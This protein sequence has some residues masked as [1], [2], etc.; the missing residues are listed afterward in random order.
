[1]K[2]CFFCASSQTLSE[3]YYSLATKFA[4]KI[5][6]NNHTLVSGGSNVGL[7]LTLAQSVK[8]INGNSIGIITKEFSERNLTCFD[9]KEIIITADLQERK[10]ILIEI[11]DAFVILPGGF[12]TLDEL[13]EVL[14][15]NHIG[16]IFKP[17]VIFNYNEFYNDL[18][19]MFDKIF[20]NN[21]AQQKNKTSYLVTQNIDETFNYI[22]SNIIQK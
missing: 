12:G 14:T 10:K 22:N 7:M 13:L 19:K 17:I 5:I 11:S 4:E 2:I 21:F 3:D 20:E 15:L 18:L 6:E 8:K 9:N 1:M 16:E